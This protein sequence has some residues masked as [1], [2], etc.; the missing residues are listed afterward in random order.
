MTLEMS[1]KEECVSFPRMEG[2]VAALGW[3]GGERGLTLQTGGV[4][5]VSGC[6]GPLRPPLVRAISQSSDLQTLRESPWWIPGGWGWPPVRLTPAGYPPDLCT[7]LAAPASRR[8]CRSPWDAAPRGTELWMGELGEGAGLAPHLLSV[9]GL[10]LPVPSGSCLSSAPVPSGCTFLQFVP[11]PQ[12]PG[13]H[14][15]QP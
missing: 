14:S 2:E 13:E 8:L 5:S 6:D 9:Q 3:D 10:R 7:P 15:P 12:S 4:G 1:S 11:G